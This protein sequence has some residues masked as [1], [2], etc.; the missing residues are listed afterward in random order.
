MCHGGDSYQGQIQNY[1]FATGRKSE[2]L[3]PKLS[4]C[5]GTEI[6]EFRDHDKMIFFKPLR[7]EFRSRVE[8]ELE[9]E[10]DIV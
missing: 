2:S 5:D 6:R 9:H 8:L 7:E 3:N 4:F 10:E 1:R